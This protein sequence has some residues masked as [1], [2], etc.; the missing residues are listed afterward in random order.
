[1]TVKNLEKAIV[2]RAIRHQECSRV[3][4]Q[5]TEWAT[6]CDDRDIIF[7]LRGRNRIV[8]I[9]NITLK[10]LKLVQNQEAATTTLS[11]PEKAIVDEE[12]RPGDCGRV[13]FQNSWWPAKCDLDMTFQRG[14]LVNVLGIDNITLLV[15]P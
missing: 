3:D 1:M 6:R 14:E 8:G 12:I 10:K 9:D 11:N 15:G 4:F 5:S 13:H 7:Q 2:D